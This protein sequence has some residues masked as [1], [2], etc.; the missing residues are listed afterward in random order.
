MKKKELLKKVTEALT[1]STKPTIVEIDLLGEELYTQIFRMNFIHSLIYIPFI[2]ASVLLFHKIDHLAFISEDF[3][4]PFLAILLVISVLNAIIFFTLYIYNKSKKE[5]ISLNGLKNAYKFYQIYD[6]FSFIG[7][8][9]TVFLWIVL[10]V[11]TPVEVSGT[12]MENTY[13]DGDKVLVWHM[14][15]TPQ[16]ND[17]VIID[18]IDYYTSHDTEFVIK[19]IIA[20][21]GDEVEYIH[22]T[23]DIKVNGETVISNVDYEVYQR[24]MSDIENNKEYHLDGIVPEGY[25]IVLGDN[26]KVSEDSRKVGLISYDA[27]LGKCIFRIYPLSDIGIPQ[28]K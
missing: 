25:C 21:A 26:T 15:Y 19:R 5:L 27:I 20:V 12:S 4:V 24:M 9:L 14:E 18:A 28:R 7:I 3:Y 10:F 1:S 2:I 13:H 11:V 6:I 16:R 8:F 17:V 23:R 22:D